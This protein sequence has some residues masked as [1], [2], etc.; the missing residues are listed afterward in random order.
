MSPLRLV[1]RVLI[2]ACLMLLA[3][4]LGY[5]LFSLLLGLIPVHGLPS[6]EAPYEVMLYS[7]GIHLDICVPAQSSICDWQAWFPPA[8]FG[9]SSQRAQYISFGWGDSAFYVST[10]T[11]DDLDMR[12]TLEA[13]TMPTPSAM[14]VSYLS[15]VPTKSLGFVRIPVTESQLMRLTEYI[16]STLERGSDGRPIRFHDSFYPANPDAFYLA[17]TSYHAFHTCNDWVNRGLKQAEMPA[18]V[19]T[20][21]DRLILRRVR[22]AISDVPDLEE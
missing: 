12:T 4:V 18:V 21:I 19:W 22:E 14:H 10:P 11:W 5:S 1:F 8:D 2:R 17:R 3:G 7:T 16:Q 6:E 13:I 9:V 20:P 15:A